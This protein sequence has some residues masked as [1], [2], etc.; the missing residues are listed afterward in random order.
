MTTR[1]TIATV[2][3]YKVSSPQ[4]FLFYIYPSAVSCS[5]FWINGVENWLPWTSGG[6]APLRSVL[7]AGGAVAGWPSPASCTTRVAPS[8]ICAASRSLDCAMLST[9]WDA[10]LPRLCMLLTHEPPCP[11]LRSCCCADRKMGSCAKSV[12]LASFCGLPAHSAMPFSNEICPV[13][14]RRFLA[15]SRNFFSC[16]VFPETVLINGGLKIARIIH[17][18]KYS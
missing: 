18:I 1:R 10:L 6:A 17:C 3:N 13:V 16:A 4:T 2:R 7:L 14:Q 8:R 15:S 11:L 5:Q 12:V 9:A